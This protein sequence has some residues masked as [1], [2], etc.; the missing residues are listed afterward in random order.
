MRKT[1]I[2]FILIFSI[3]ISFI[4]GL[5][6]SFAEE[7]YDEEP[8]ADIDADTDEEYTITEYEIQE[9]YDA[10][11]RFVI[12]LYSNVLGR[13]HD[14]EGLQFWSYLVRSGGITGANL[15]YQF[16]F[17][18]EYINKNSGIST[19]VDTLYSTL[20]DRI[21]DINGKVFW[22]D[23]LHKGMP[24]EDIFAG[25]V[26]SP[27]FE[28]ICNDA[29]ITRNIYLPPPG[30]SARMF[31]KRLYTTTLER[32]PDTEGLDF[33]HNALKSG[34]TGAEVAHSFIFSPEME[35]RNLSDSHFIE[36]L[37]NAMMGRISDEQGKDF[38]LYQ[39]ENGS[40]KQNIF[41][42]FVGSDEFFNICAE[43]GVNRGAA[44]Q[45]FQPTTPRTGKII[46]LDPGHG[47]IGSPGA[48]GYNEAVAMLDLARRIRPLLEAQ[49]FT[50]IMT[51]DSEY[52]VPI[53]ARC[54]QINAIALEA[55]RSTHTDPGAINEIDRLIGIMNNIMANPGAL[56]SVYMNVDPF[57]PSR[58]IHHDLR[59]VFEYQNN[60]VIANNF[61]VI[62]LHSNAA[63]STATRGAEAYYISPNEF[64][65][66]RHYYPGFSYTGPSWSFG[67]IL[68]NHINS[69]GIPRRWNNGLRAENYAMNREHNVPSVLVENG[70][71]TN[72][73]DR[74]LLQ[75]PGFMDSLAYAYRNAVLE[76][77]N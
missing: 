68:L 15:A 56:G 62:S 6:F 13:N 39:M 57:N 31:A 63:S 16:F 58:T 24:R 2:S 34:K 72:P 65:N 29:G 17:S 46:F 69:T 71:H 40:T 70:F 25:F 64:Y 3:T 8:T 52:N 12:R 66:T 61:L 4:S 42:G 77:F 26:N 73:S 44:P 53:S 50:V 55:V 60:P 36:I 76:Y 33:W 54:A 10:I 43:H 18:D 20:M 51:R 28:D 5:G 7:P 11:E 45:P 75:N 48:G 23:L 14:D 9:S 49:G 47:T 38:W 59:R 21:P 67:N 74:A 35:R 1:I 22:E 19:F 41:A 27:E 32:E 37:Y 30:G